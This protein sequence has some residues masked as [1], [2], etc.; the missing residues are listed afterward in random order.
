MTWTYPAGSVGQLIASDHVAEPTRI[1]LQARMAAKPGPPRWFD[2]TEFALLCGV[3]ARVIVDVPQVDIAGVIDARLAAGTGDGWR[4][5]ALPTDGEAYRQGL[6]TID[7]TARLLGGAAFLM[8][9]PEAQDAVLAA[10]Q[11]T[12]RRWFEDLLAE[13][14]ETA[15]AHPAVQGAIG[16]AGFADLP[17]WIR[18]GLD[19]REA[20]EPIDE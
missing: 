7:A 6:S 8:L 15:Y 14:A 20:H 5:D 2:A 9:G 16:Y 17:G 18:I 19:E 13:A 1:A 10:V 12:S 11:K 4:Y 3:C